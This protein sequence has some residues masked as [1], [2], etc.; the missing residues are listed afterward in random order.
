MLITPDGTADVSVFQVCHVCRRDA[1]HTA[2]RT[3]VGDRG[4]ACLRCVRLDA[5]LAHP[6][7]V[8][9]LTRLDPT[10]ARLANV[11]EHRLFPDR[12]EL[13]DPRVKDAHLAAM[14]RLAEEAADE[15]VPRLVVR[16]PAGP[17]Q[18]SHVRWEAW[19][20]RF[21]PSDLE[22]ARAYQRYVTDLHPWIDSVE[23]RVADLDWLVGVLTG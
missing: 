11:L 7:G 18:S 14:Q 16:Y 6:F 20:E 5:R 15:G 8:A 21:P 17:P 19:Q 1:A 2:R 12:L 4:R 9:L 23:P 13:V 22:S 3:R 10:L